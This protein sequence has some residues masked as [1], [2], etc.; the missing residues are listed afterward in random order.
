MR[1]GDPAPIVAQG[2]HPSPTLIS[3]LQYHWTLATEGR[4]QCD[5]G[6][7]TTPLLENSSSMLALEEVDNHE[8]PEQQARL[9]W[10]AETGRIHSGSFSAETPSE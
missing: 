6:S 1:S 9:P 7:L 2:L 3:F 4:L 10:E 5:G 8:T